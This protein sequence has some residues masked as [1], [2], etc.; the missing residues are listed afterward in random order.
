MTSQPK[1]DL[2]VVLR[3]PRRA[4]GA[5]LHAFVEGSTLEINSCYAYLLLGTHFRD[6]CLL[7]EHDD[8]LLGF[9]A[10]YRLPRR[11][12][13]LF[14]WQ[15]GVAEAARGHGLG[16]RL[17][18]T[19]V[20]RSSPSTRCLEATVERGNRA[21]QRLFEALAR[22]LGTT[23]STS[24]GFTTEDFGDAPHDDEVLHRVGP[25]ETT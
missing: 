10:A 21:S 22:E 24:R 7:A 16:L 12:D 2:D 14:V 20:A 19:L 11:P 23:C 5:R 1:T 13:T 15:V 17:L 6:T 4:D 8:E 9:V 3:R 18:H 25:W